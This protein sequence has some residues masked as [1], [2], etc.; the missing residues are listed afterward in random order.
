LPDV[1]LFEFPLNS[2]SE[3]LGG[4]LEEVFHA[5]LGIS[6]G[7]GGVSPDVVER[8]LDLVDKLGDLTQFESVGL[9]K[10]LHNL[11]KMLVNDGS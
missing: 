8:V 6:R 4:H 7:D 11:C 5:G 1:V 2:C 10:R 9:R 3:R